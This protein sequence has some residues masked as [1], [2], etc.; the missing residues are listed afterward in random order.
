MEP[1]EIFKFKT[2]EVQNVA[3]TG[4][5][6]NSS[7]F[8]SSNRTGIVRV[9]CTTDAYI[10]VGNGVTATTTTGAYFAAG[11]PDYIKVAEGDRISAIQVS[12]AGSLNITPLSK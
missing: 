6:G 9:V 2:S 12:A 3:Y 8:T 1:I 4:T 7:A 5:A 10:S 11:I